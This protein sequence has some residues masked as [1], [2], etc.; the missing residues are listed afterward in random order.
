MVAHNGVGADIDS[1]YVRYQLYAIYQ[2]LAAMVEV[3]P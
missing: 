1:E 3:M 2:P